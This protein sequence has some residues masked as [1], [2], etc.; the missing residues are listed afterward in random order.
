VIE[1]LAA[2]TALA[3]LALAG[4]AGFVAIKGHFEWRRALILL[5]VLEIAL[6]VD[7]IADVIGLARGHHPKEP[8][9]HLA[10]L[11]VS[12]V[13]GPIVAAQ[14]FGDGGRWAAGLT[15]VAGIAIA[16]VVVR[17]Q[18]TWRP[19]RR[20]SARGRRSARVGFWCAATDCSSWPQVH[21][22]PCNWRP[23][24]DARR[25]PTFCRPLPP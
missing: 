2:A 16:V 12:L 17:A 21:A 19:A 13:I 9:T 14:V 24:L 3:G 4:W 11:I 6:V 15:A 20:V 22:P 5:T 23:M 10:Y 18:T 7:V 25:W 1:S 8:A